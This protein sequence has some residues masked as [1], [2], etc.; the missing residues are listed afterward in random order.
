MR[1]SVTAAELLEKLAVE[2]YEPPLSEI[3]ASGAIADVSNPLCVVMLL[4]D[5][6]TEVSMN[7]ITNF[8]GNS[9]GRYAAQTVTALATAGC[10][11]EAE[12]LGRIL[13][14]ASSAGMTHESIQSDRSGLEPY[15][16]TS[17]SQL[18]GEKWDDVAD[19]IGTIAERI[20]F[21][22][23]LEQTERFVAER[24]ASIDDA[25]RGRS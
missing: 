20:D 23:V 2:I 6:E 9:T 11:V 21:G 3:R 10:S 18:H 15:A 8:L 12:A 14:L 16:V 1:T 25:L 5:F 13:D 17:F 24:G 22:F 4:L 7:G 19:K